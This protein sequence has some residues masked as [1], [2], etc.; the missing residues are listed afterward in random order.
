MLTLHHAP[1]TRSFR[2]LWLLEEI[3]E[4]YELVMR[5]YRA[6][7]GLDES[8]RAIHPHKKVP[9]LVHDGTTVTES[10]AIC[11]YLADAFPQAGLGAPIGDPKRGPLLTWLAYYAGVIEPAFMAQVMK[12]T[13]DPQ[14]AGWGRFE[15]VVHTL[16]NALSA[17]PY[18][19]G[20]RF[21]VAD[22]LVFSF[23]QMGT[24]GARILPAQPPFT[25]YVARLIARPAYQRALA[26]DGG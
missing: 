6:D 11:L 3:G 21:S 23:V 19:L 24:Q 10:A 8:Y 18:V 9:A 16:H 12:W 4:P 5:N 15:D 2:I 7:G 26:R 17:S 13:Y 25:D 1:K 22:V 20:E 14:M